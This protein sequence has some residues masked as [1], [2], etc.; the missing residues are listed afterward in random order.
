M[1][2]VTNHLI[3][4]LNKKIDQLTDELEQVKKE[5]KSLRLIL[6]SHGEIVVMNHNLKEEIKYL[7]TAL[8]VTDYEQ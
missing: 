8:G 2:E 3:K 5:N 4:N 6:K 1:N 7:K